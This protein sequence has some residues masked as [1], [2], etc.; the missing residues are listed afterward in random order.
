MNKKLSD[1]ELAHEFRQHRLYFEYL[2]SESITEEIGSQSASV[3]SL[4]GSRPVSTISAKYEELKI[5][6]S[7]FFQ[8]WWSSVRNRKHSP[9]KTDVIKML[10]VVQTNEQLLIKLK[11]IFGEYDQFMK[12]Y[13][14]L[15]A[16]IQKQLFLIVCSHSVIILVAIHIFTEIYLEWGDLIDEKNIKLAKFNYTIHLV[17]IFHDF[18]CL[19]LTA[20]I[21]RNEVNFINFKIQ[22]K[23]QL[24]PTDKKYKSYNYKI[25]GDTIQC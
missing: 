5:Q 15:E 7:V 24:T 6:D 3:S 11:S 21:C 23:T 19:A 4:N 14:K 1:I 12:M 17:H 25:D 18:G 10:N 22:I 9:R 2:K 13:R 20:I 16:L 8:K